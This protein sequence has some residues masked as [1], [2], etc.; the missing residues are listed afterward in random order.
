MSEE[1]IRR[2]E[3]P[4]PDEVHRS[5]W[6]D[7]L[8]AAAAAVEIAKDGPAVVF[9]YKARIKDLFSKDDDQAP[10]DGDE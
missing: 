2:V 9:D 4:S 7:G 3:Q 1:E 5:W 10:D 6:L 8:V